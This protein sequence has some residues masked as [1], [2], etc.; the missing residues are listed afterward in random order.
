MRSSAIFAFALALAAPAFSAASSSNDNA[1][2]Q[3]AARNLA[4]PP[5]RS[6]HATRDHR[7]AGSVA[8]TSS[9]DFASVLK[10][11]K[12]SSKAKRGKCSAGKKQTVISASEDDAEGTV[13]GE[14]RNTTSSSSGSSSGSGANWDLSSN[15]LKIGNIFAGFLPDDGSGGGSK[16]SMS[17]INSALPAKSAWYGRYAQVTAGKTFDG[18]QLYSVLDD[19]K[20]SGSILAASVMPY[21]TWYGLTESDNHNAVAIAKVCNDIYKTHGIE[22]WLRFAHEMNWYQV[23]GTYT[24]GVSDFQTGWKVLAKA[25][26]EHAPE[27]KLWWSP[28]VGSDSDYERY[29]PQEGRVDVVGFDWYPND[30]Y[31]ESFYERAKP[32]H[33]RYTK[34]GAI[35]VQGETGLH[36]TGSDEEKMQ[37]VKSLSDD[38][39]QSLSNYMGWMWFNYDK[40]ENGRQVDFKIIKPGQSAA[41]TSKAVSFFTS[42]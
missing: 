41:I 24:G 19:V 20:E 31:K 10:K 4:A 3:L 15:F 39:A 1:A 6:R 11:H 38:K 33:D 12:R 9:S 27:T 26:E 42:H 23:D 34:D 18:N 13:G 21:K 40:Y 28:N 14:Q 2:G 35:M 25:I 36:Y 7:S 16:E 29:W 22:V 37:W 17:Q 32:F 5:A 8:S 30:P